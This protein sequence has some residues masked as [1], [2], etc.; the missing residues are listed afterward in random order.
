MSAELC[1]AM[2]LGLAPT[3]SQHFHRFTD[4]VAVAVR[5]GRWGR[6]SCCWGTARYWWASSS[7]CPCL[8]DYQMLATFISLSKVSDSREEGRPIFGVSCHLSLHAP[9]TVPDLSNLFLEHLF[10]AGLI[11]SNPII[12]LWKWRCSS[13]PICYLQPHLCF[14]SWIATLIWTWLWMCS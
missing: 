4:F 13:L 14:C 6:V 12:K 11:C 10:F 2:L 7:W 5:T 9:A 8:G 3:K 1:F